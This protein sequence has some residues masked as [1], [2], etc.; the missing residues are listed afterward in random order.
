MLVYRSALA[1]PHSVTPLNCYRMSKSHY[2]QKKIF[3]K[4]FFKCPVDSPWKV[5]HKNVEKKFRLIPNLFIIFLKI[6]FLTRVSSLCHGQTPSKVV[7]SS[8]IFYLRW[9]WP[10]PRALFF[11]FQ[12]GPL[13]RRL[14]GFSYVKTRFLE[15]F[16]IFGR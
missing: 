10:F 1:W 5:V 13:L 12:F 14:Y 15:N 6:E 7:R 8:W 11:C 2:H 16:P 4:I 9:P 3:Q